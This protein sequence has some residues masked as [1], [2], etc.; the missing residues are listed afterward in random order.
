[1]L[2][3]GGEVLGQV[4]PEAVIALLAGSDQRGAAGP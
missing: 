1:V 2:G 3:R 4:T